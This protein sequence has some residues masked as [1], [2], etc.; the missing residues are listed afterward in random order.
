MLETMRQY[1][2]AGQQVV[3]PLYGVAKGPHDLEWDILH[4]NASQHH[5]G[6]TVQW[7]DP[8]NP[9]PLR[10]QLDKNYRHGGG[11]TPFQGHT[12]TDTLSLAYPGDPLVQP[13][14]LCKFRDEEWLIVYPHAWFLILNPKTRV[15]V[16]ARMD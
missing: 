13:Y 7:I 16:V 5:L 2:I 9:E 3:V 14:W 6:Y 11:Y 10:V 4:P 12:L 15:W 8:N 1:E